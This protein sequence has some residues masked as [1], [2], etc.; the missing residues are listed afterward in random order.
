MK[1]ITF[2]L[3]SLLPGACFHFFESFLLSVYDCLAFSFGGFQKNVG[4]KQTP[5]KK[6][7]NE[8]Y[9]PKVV[10]PVS[11]GQTLRRYLQS[12]VL[13]KKLLYTTNLVLSSNYYQKNDIHA[14]ADART[15]WKASSQSMRSLAQ[16]ALIICGFCRIDAQVARQDVRAVPR[17]SL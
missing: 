16:I 2:V 7:K 9:L 17:V 15:Y 12:F 8:Q 10:V 13:L 4:N 6:A 14:Y 5:N 11:P 3:S 1:S